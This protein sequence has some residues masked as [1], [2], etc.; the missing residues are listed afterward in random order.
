MVLPME[1]AQV[2]VR[3]A[4]SL[5]NTVIKEVSIPEI[6]ILKAIHGHDAVVE[7]SKTRTAEVEQ[8][9]ERDRLDKAYGTPIL[10]KLFPGVTS[11]LPT[12]L[13]DIGLEQPVE[14][15]AKKK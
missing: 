15:T 5:E 13:V 9:A 3:L 1:Y 14:A 8:A 11:K 7:I 10:E 6:P 12:T 2:T 4:G